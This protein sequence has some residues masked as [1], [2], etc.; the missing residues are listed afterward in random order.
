MKLAETFLR[1]ERQGVHNVNLVTP[2]HFV[3]PIVEAIKLARDKGLTVPF[4][5]NTNAY[6]SLRSLK[7]LDGLIDI[8]M[9]DLK[10]YDDTLGQRYSN[11]PDYFSVA[12]EALLEM[13]R[14]VGAPIIENG[15]MQKGILIRHLVMP[16][17]TEDSLAVLDWIKAHIPSALVNV[18]PQYRPEYLAGN[19]PEINRRTTAS[20]YHIITN[21]LHKLN[22]QPY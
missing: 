18:M 7:M 4:V 20:K 17:L 5:Y 13:A 2:S 6:D 21:Y 19:Y 10:Y 15:V 22:L 16:G 1:L 9:P 3:P 12:S 8:Y 14:Q 11:V